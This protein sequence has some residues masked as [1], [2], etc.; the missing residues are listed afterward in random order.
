MHKD[1]ARVSGHGFTKPGETYPGSVPGFLPQT[2]AIKLRLIDSPW[3]TRAASFS[4]FEAEILME[5]YEQIKERIKEKGNSAT[6]VK[7]REKV[8]QRITDRL[9]A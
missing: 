8:W 2:T 5:A 9:S 4:T 6:V 7:Q 3:E 1:Q